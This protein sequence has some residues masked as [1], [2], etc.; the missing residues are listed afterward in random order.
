[1]ITM[2]S[3]INL[4]ESQTLDEAGAGASRIVSH[5]R[6]GDVFMAISAFRA[7]KPMAVNMKRTESL[8]AH[9]AKLPVA[10]I[11]TT[12]E[13]HEIGQDEPSEEISFFVLPKK[14]VPLSAV[15]TWGKKLR[16]LFDQDSFIYGDGETIHLVD[17][18][19]DY[20]IG[21]RM[22]FSPKAL[23]DAPGITKVKNKPFTYMHKDDE[24]AP[25][26]TV[27]G[28]DAQAKP[29]QADAA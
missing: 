3:L 29:G 9:F 21:D 13:Y 5:I 16:A 6:N 20:E 2:R 27:Y 18:E 10:Y 14:G 7:D 26:A 28:A 15:I 25:K 17:A 8:K 24:K 4:V 12:G 23:R 22:S 19:G 1:M 11:V